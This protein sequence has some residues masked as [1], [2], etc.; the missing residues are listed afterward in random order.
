VKQTAQLVLVLIAGIVIG[1]WG[2]P[3]L[4]AQTAGHPAYVVAEVHVTDPAGFMN[5]AKQ[6]PASLAPYHGKTLARALPDVREGAPPDGDMVI[7]AFDSLQ[8]ANRWY[9]SPEYSKLIPLRQQSAT[10]RVLIVDGMPQ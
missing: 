7:I 8:D 5:Y 10:T 9:Q 6:V 3:I 2:V 4:K 1:A